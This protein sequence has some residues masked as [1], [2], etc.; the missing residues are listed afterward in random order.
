[1]CEKLGGQNYH[2]MIGKKYELSQYPKDTNFEKDNLITNNIYSNKI[3]KN[4]NDKNNLMKIIPFSENYMKGNKNNKKTTSLNYKYINSIG[5]N[6]CACT[7]NTE[8]TFINDGEKVIYN[9]LIIGTKE[10]MSPY[11]LKGI[12]SIRTD[13]YSIGVTIY[14]ILF[15]NFP[16]LFDE[17]SI[18]KWEHFVINKNKNI[19]IPFSFLFHNI[20][21]SYFIKLMDIYLINN[22]IYFSKNSYLL[23]NKFKELEKIENI[24]FDFKQFKIN[25]NNIYLIQILKKSLSL[26]INEQYTNVSEILENKFFT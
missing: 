24:K 18:R 2:A 16:Y 7:G 22:N 25:V 9:D 12:Y 26:E 3:Y 10:Y 19:L 14:L 17:I 15:K 11:C 6:L 1:M 20:N 21:C 5:R 13:I 23:D 8:K 4:K